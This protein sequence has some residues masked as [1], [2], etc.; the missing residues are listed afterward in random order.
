MIVGAQTL[1]I[2]L[3][4]LDAYITRRNLRRQ[5]VAL[6]ELLHLEEQRRQSRESRK[7]KS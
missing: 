2:V 3:L 7:A 5:G 1:A 6:A 4:V